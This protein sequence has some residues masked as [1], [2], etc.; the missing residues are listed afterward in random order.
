M[1]GVG[2]RGLRLGPSE[3]NAGARLGPTE[4]RVR[5][6]RMWPSGT[7]CGAGSR[8]HS[9]FLRGVVWEFLWKFLEILEVFQKKRKSSK[10]PKTFKKMPIKFSENQSHVHPLPTPPVPGSLPPGPRGRP[11][12]P[13]SQVLWQHGKTT[14]MLYPCDGLDDGHGESAMSYILGLGRHELLNLPRVRRLLQA[15]WVAFG[16]AFLFQRLLRHLVLLTIFQVTLYQPPTPRTPPPQNERWREADRRRQRPTIRSRGLVP[17]PPP[18]HPCA[19][20]LSCGLSWMP[21]QLQAPPPPPPRGQQ[22]PPKAN[23]V[24]PR[25]CADPHPHPHSRLIVKQCAET[26]TPRAAPETTAGHTIP[27]P[28]NSHEPHPPQVAGAGVFTHRMVKLRSANQQHRVRILVY[29]H[30]DVLLA[31]QC[32]KRLERLSRSGNA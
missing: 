20:T 3:S 13:P 4:C 16:Q 17:T 2:G 10:V 1:A 31:D 6:T 7:R 8:R 28:H 32:A 27:P 18:P 30:H 23:N 15:K 9:V 5:Q 12:P 14:F 29:C 26:C 22:A 24:I 11:R 25:P 19:V 21:Q